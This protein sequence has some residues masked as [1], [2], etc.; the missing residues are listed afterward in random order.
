MRVWTERAPRAFAIDLAAI[1]WL[2]GSGTTSW[3][4][5]GYGRFVSLTEGAQCALPGRNLPN[6]GVDTRLD[7]IAG[8][9]PGEPLAFF[10]P[11]PDAAGSDL[12]GLAFEL[13][14]PSRSVTLALEPGGGKAEV[15]LA[16]AHATISTPEGKTAMSFGEQA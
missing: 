10:R 4:L 11:H 5:P 8:H 15:D 7:A 2:P 3:V 16:N 1:D 12:A 9:L 6:V 14:E 13:N